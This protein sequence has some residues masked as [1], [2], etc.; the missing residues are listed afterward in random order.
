MGTGRGRQGG[1]G[2][3]LLLN[4][5]VNVFLPII[6]LTRLSGE[7]WLGP[8]N[9]F[10]AAMALPIG[11]GL[12]D[13]AARRKVN[14]LSVLGF[15]GV[16]GTT[17]IGMLRLDPGLVAVKEAAVPLAIGLA[18]LASTRTR[19]PVVKKVMEKVVDM[20]RIRAALRRR[21]KEQAFERKL[22]SAG[23]MV[24][25]VFFVSSALNYALAKWI[26]VSQPGTA[27]FNEELGLMAAMSW[28]F[29]ALPSLAL[30]GLIAWHLARSVS[31]MTG[32]KVED[33][34]RKSG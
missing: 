27:A 23:Y 15:A 24:A 17:A 34:L 29:I 16:L 1:K 4:I 22:A 14:L 12:Y 26:V 6:I 30:L 5:A 8:T 31:A 32:M 33:V 10:I 11:Y 9:G 18:V 28:P 13:F 21:D 20:E 19:W 7:G 3:S 25:A 2:E